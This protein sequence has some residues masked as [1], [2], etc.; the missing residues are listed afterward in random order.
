MGGNLG[1]GLWWEGCWRKVKVLELK[2]RVQ[3]EELGME[4]LAMSA[5]VGEVLGGQLMGVYPNK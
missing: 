5:V 4:L 2:G 1:V 3:W